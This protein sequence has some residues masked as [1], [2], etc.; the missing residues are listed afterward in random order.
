M[1]QWGR[2]MSLK[3]LYELMILFSGDLPEGD[4]KK[5]IEVIKK[6]LNSL[7]AEK[8]EEDYWGRKN[9]AY[10]LGSDYSGYFTFLKMMMDGKDIET[11]KSKLLSNDKLLR[12]MITKVG[13][14]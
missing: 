3:H 8:I 7:G 9:L 1:L 12:Q 11:L 5:E 4:V 13:G 2:I 10:K 6:E 14:I